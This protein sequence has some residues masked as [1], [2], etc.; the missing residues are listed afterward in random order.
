MVQKPNV[1]LIIF[2]SFGKEY[3]GFMNTKTHIP[4]FESYTPFLDS[5]AQH[6]FVLDNAYCTGRQSIHG[7]SS[8]LAGIPSFQVAYKSSPFV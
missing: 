3:W 1:V 2:E 4:N 5:L 6:S 7:L 8:M